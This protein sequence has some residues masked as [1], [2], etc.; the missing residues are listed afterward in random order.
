MDGVAQV[1]TARPAGHGQPGRRDDTA[2]IATDSASSS[3]IVFGLFRLL[4]D[5]FSR[6]HRQ[7]L[8]YS[9]SGWPARSSTVSAWSYATATTRLLSPTAMTCH[10][11][12]FW[13]TCGAGC[14]GTGDA[15]VSTREPLSSASRAVAGRGDLWDSTVRPQ[16][17]PARI[18]AAPQTLGT[19]R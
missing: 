1:T 16:F 5:Q 15:G 18:N 8:T 11:G 4:G 17:V 6:R 13:A 3:D 7:W 2:L 12:T 14:S 19:V 10:G 9:T